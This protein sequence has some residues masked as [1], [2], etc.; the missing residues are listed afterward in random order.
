MNRQ[1]H[2]S[3]RRRPLLALCTFL[4]AILVL[5]APA[6]AAPD[7][8]RLNREPATSSRQAVWQCCQAT[9]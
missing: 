5:H 3:V 1:K 6:S 9:A 4:L 7:Q 2:D 8:K